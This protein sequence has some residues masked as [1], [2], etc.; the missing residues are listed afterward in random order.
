MDSQVSLL[1]ATGL[2][3]GIRH[4]FDRDHVA[5]VTHFVSLEHDPAKSA[6]FGLRWALGHAVS[7]GLLGSLILLLGLKFDP[8]FERTAE[9]LVGISLVALGLW[10]LMLLFQE[11]THTHRHA[12]PAAEKHEHP[13]SHEPGDPHV[14]W[15]APTFVGL[16]HGAAGA[17]EIFVLIP[18]TFI[19]SQALAYAYIGLFSAGCA[20]SM[21]G[22]GWLAGHFY[23]RADATGKKIYRVLVVLTALSGFFI[24]AV[25]I[26]KN[27]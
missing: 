27:L 20:V 19:T 25:W 16:L 14:H 21:S 22:Y 23:R 8:A 18:I 2:V 1:F 13:H 15:F 5:A 4:A 12:H 10:R 6:W 26:V 17:A 9:L 7:V 24:G 3:L 11:R